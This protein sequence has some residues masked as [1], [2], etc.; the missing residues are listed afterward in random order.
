MA[1]E[2][3]I[4]IEETLSK[5]VNITADSKEDALKMVRRQYYAA[6]IVLN[7][8]DFN[9]VEFKAIEEKDSKSE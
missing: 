8:N 7:E 4:E 1:K 5:R 6:N 3:I 9:N 2:Y